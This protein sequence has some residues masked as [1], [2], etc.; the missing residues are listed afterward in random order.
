MGTRR[1]RFGDWA[2]LGLEGE[3]HKVI[4]LPDK[5]NMDGFLAWNLNSINIGTDVDNSFP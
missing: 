1:R 4:T 5:L 3:G 2:R